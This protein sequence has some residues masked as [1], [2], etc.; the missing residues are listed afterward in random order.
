[1]DTAPSQRLISGQSTGEMRIIIAFYGEN[2]HVFLR[3]V[4]EFLKGEVMS[5]GGD[6]VGEGH[7]V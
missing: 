5:M 3:H 7:L 6:G 1:M 4:P 2:G